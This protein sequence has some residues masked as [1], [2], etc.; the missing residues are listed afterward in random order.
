MSFSSNDGKKLR[1][2]K[3]RYGWKIFIVN[4]DNKLVFEFY[5]HKGHSL[6]PRRKWIKTAQSEFA[7]VYNKDTCEYERYPLRFHIYLERP[8]KSYDNIVRKV[9]WKGPVATG[10]QC[11]LLTV[12]ANQLIVN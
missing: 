6:V 5:P 4:T 2:Y 3:Q 9:H 11:G 10:Y 8:S 7:S 12:V 1:S